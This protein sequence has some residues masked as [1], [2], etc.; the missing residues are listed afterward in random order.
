MTFAECVVVFQ[1]YAFVQL[2]ALA[3]AAAPAKIL[4]VDRTWQLS[5]IHIPR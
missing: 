3:A 4:R 5:I 2:G 1:L